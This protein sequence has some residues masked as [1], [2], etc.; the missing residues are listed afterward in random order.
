MMWKKIF[1]QPVDFFGLLREQAEYITE[2]VQALA[3][4]AQNLK[5]EDAEK[6]KS[7]EKQA[8]GK[9]FEL[10]Q[11]LSET[12]ITPYDRED[13]FMLSKALDDVLD[14]FKTAVKEMEIYQI[15][16]SQELCRFIDALEDASRNINSAVSCMEKQPKESVRYAVAAKKCENKVE[17]LYRH[18]VAALLECDDIKYII[19]MRELYRHLSNCADRID[20][21][22][23]C[24][25]QIL[26]KQIS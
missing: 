5:E 14:Y 22:S 11:R 12:F 7:L 23:D 3:A 26:M 17:S 15:G 25:C 21:A 13:I 6:V 1:R 10:V 2:A 18:S 24:V 4:F 8:D 19:K 9:R 16:H 20:E